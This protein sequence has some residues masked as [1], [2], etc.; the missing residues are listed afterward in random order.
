VA[1][2]RG[3]R[4]PRLSG[5]GDASRTEV[6][7]D[8]LSFGSKIKPCLDRGASVNFESTST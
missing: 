8:S 6:L 1:I 4:L 3:S 2:V 5:K 7:S